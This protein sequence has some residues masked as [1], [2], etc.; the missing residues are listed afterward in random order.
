MNFK[1]QDQENSSLMGEFATDLCRIW[2]WKWFFAGM[3]IEDATVR[4]FQSSFRDWAGS[5]TNFPRDHRE[6]AGARY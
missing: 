3:K 6:G 1:E 2:R 4:G 5:V